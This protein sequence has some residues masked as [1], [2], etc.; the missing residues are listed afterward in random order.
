MSRL[1]SA[2]IVVSVVV[3]AYGVTCQVGAGDRV[4]VRVPFTTDNKN[5]N[6]DLV[7]GDKGMVMSIDADGDAEIS[8][9]RDGQTHWV[10]RGKFGKK[11]QRISEAHVILVGL[12]CWTGWVGTLSFVSSVAGWRTRHP[13]YTSRS[14]QIAD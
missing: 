1:I 12:L 4:E 6:I 2:L 5:D 7:E 3:A 9:D 10:Y 13:R 11:L 14:A 8:F